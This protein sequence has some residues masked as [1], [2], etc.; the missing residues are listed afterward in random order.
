[1]LL[2]A[3]WLSE[4][5]I[6]VVNVFGV[7][8]KF[9]LTEKSNSMMAEHGYYVFIVDINATKSQIADAVEHAFNVKVDSVNT[10]SLARKA[11]RVRSK[12]VRYVLVGDRKK[13]IVSLKDG[14]KIEVA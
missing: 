7:L 2:L 3:V 11:K 6:D 10:M 12:S 1:M 14:Y 9:C 4:L 8:K 13:A 5:E